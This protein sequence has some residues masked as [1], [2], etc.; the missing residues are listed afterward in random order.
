MRKFLAKITLYTISLIMVV[1]IWPILVF[2]LSP[3]SQTFQLTI[4][5]LTPG[6]LWSLALLHSKTFD[7]ACSINQTQVYENIVSEFQFNFTSCYKYFQPSLHQFANRLTRT[8]LAA[9]ILI[10]PR[11]SGIVPFEYYKGTLADT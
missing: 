8:Y 3:Q 4:F 10:K 1:S 6:I 5:L 9:I 7:F 11:V 2:K